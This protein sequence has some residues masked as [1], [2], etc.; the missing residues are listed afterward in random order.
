MS[1]HRND[2]LDLHPVAV[3][4]DILGSRPHQ[5]AA[6]RHDAL[7]ESARAPKKGRLRRLAALAGRRGP[8]APVARAHSR[9]C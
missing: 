3:V 8:E 6:A 1:N 5:A 9:G 4:S 2:L 7:P